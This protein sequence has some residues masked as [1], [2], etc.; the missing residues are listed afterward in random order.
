MS[1][2]LSVLMLQKVA[3]AELLMSQILSV[4]MLQ[5]VVFLSVYWE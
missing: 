2:I 3:K 5:K 1:Q 4:L